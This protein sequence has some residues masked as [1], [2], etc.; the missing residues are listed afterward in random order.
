MSHVEERPGAL[1]FTGAAMHW[2]GVAWRGAPGRTGQVQPG[3]KE[4]IV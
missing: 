1:H 3:R 4:E 2:R